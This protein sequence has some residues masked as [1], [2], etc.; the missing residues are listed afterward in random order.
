MVCLYPIWVTGHPITTIQHCVIIKNMKKI[1][2]LFWVPTI[3]IFLFEGVLVAFTSHTKFAIEGITHLGY[4]VYFATILS[5]FKVLGALVLIIPKIPARIKEWAYAGFGIDFICASISIT[6]VDGLGF[7][8]IFP[9]IFLGLL[10]LS[11]VNYH[12][13]NP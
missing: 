12:K 1:K 7:G 2:I 8:A 9:L 5:V 11:Y 10:A 4:P 13:L 3:I 6:M